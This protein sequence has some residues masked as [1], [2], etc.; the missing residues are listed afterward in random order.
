MVF[1]DGGWRTT[2]EVARA[3]GVK[4]AVVFG[5]LRRMHA[6]RWIE[7][8]CDPDP[9]TRGTQ[10]R[11]T[12]LGRELLDA[13]LAEERRV[14]ELSDG[15]WL[16][17]VEEQGLDE[18][19]T[20]EFHRA[21]KDPQLSGSLAWGAP[22]GWGWLLAFDSDARKFQR[23]ELAIELGRAGFR[24]REARLDELLTGARLRERAVAH[25]EKRTVR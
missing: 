4:A 1:S 5:T 11:L 8:D 18:D 7:A 17:L 19:R 13:A 10:Y 9:P 6:D 2:Q 23:D 21:M 15:Q 22:F 12:K 20:L 16:L 24:C 14:G 25:I 3:R